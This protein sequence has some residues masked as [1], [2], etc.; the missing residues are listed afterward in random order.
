VPAGAGPVVATAAHRED[1]ARPRAGRV[2]R[3]PLP[4]PEGARG[5]GRRL[6]RGTSTRRGRPDQLDQPV[7]G[8]LGAARAAPAPH[9]TLRATPHP[10][11]P[12]GHP[13]RCR[14]PR[15]DREHL[16]QHPG[17]SL[18]PHRHRADYRT[19]LSL[20]RIVSQPHRAGDSGVRRQTP[21]SG[22]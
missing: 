16:A 2:D 12:V 15:E 9:R 10:R 3:R 7:E 19:V 5:R 13:G 6:R 1:R 21:D 4:G 17:P 22:R 14:R 20:V 8:H 18:R 11:R